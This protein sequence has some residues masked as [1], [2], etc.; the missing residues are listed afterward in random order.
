MNNTEPEFTP[1][2]A[3]PTS[4]LADIHDR[5]MEAYYGKMGEQFMRE[6]QSR[7]HWICA[8]VSGRKVL[9]VGCSQGIVPLLLAREGC[10]VTGVDISP[11]AI[12][13]AKG[14][15]QSEPEHVQQKVTYI[16]ADFLS[17]D[18]QDIVADT[19]VISEVLEHLVRPEL[20][21]EKAANLL[22]PGGCLIITV[23]F[24]V[25]DFID[26]KQTF[27]VLEPYRLLN[28][29]LQICEIK[30]IGKWLGM[31]ARKVEKS[32][33][34]S[35][36]VFDIEY[37][38]QLEEAFESIER[39]LRKSFVELSNRLAQANSKYRT[40]TEQI[41]QLKHQ[42][43]SLELAKNRLTQ[44]SSQQFAHLESRLA[45]AQVQL[46]ARDRE[47]QALLAQNSSAHTQLSKELAV[48][49]NKLHA[50]NLKY[51]A[52]TGEQIPA[53]KANLNSLQ[54][55][56][57]AQQHR[58][59]LLSTD[60]ARAI[61]QRALAEQRLIKTRASTTFQLGY[62]IKSSAHS[63]GGILRL[64][65]KL[66]R[67]YRKASEQR[68]RVTQKQ[69][70]GATPNVASILPP[71]A[72]IDRQLPVALETSV[73][74]RNTLLRSADEP[75]RSIKVA[76]IMDAFTFSSYRFECDLLQLTPQHWKQELDSFQPALLFI[77]SA[78]RG[79]DGLWGSKV[80]HN[81]QELQ[82]ILGWCKQH[83][84]PTV[85]WNKEDPVHFESFLNT[86]KQF[87]H[88][89]TTDIDCIH[90]YK[91][92][93]GH[94]RVYLLP[95]ACQPA[96]HNPVELYQRKEAFC[97]AGAYYARYPERTQ[98]LGNF[99]AHL[100]TL[101]P[102]DIFDRNFG[103]NDANYQF[104][105]AYQPFIVGTLAFEQIDMAYKGYRYALN[106]NSIKQSQ[107]MF[108]RRV[109]ELLGSNTLTVSNFSRGVRLLFGEL[110]LSTD[111]AEEVQRRL[112]RLAD[113][114]Q[115]ID[116][117]RLAALRKVMLEH[118]YEQRLGYVLSK[119]HGKPAV[120]QLPEI[121]VL[122]A[123]VDRQ[124]FEAL[125]AHLARQTHPNVRLFIVTDGFDSTGVQEDPRVR[126]FKRQSINKIKIAELLGNT[127]WLA[128]FAAQDY[129]GPNYL[130]DLA[131][132]TRYSQALLVG[133]AAYSTW[134]GKCVELQQAEQAYR[135]TRQFAARR[136]LIA[137]QLVGEQS[138][139]AWFKALPSLH[140][141]HEL[142][143]A[144]DA[145]N[146]CEN[147]S[148]CPSSEV[149]QHVDDL[150]L[151]DG[152]SIDQLQA[153]AEAIA[154][155]PVSHDARELSGRELSELFGALGSKCIDLEV[156]TDSWQVRSDLGDGKHE[157]LYAKQELGLEQL[158]SANG[159]LKLYLDCTP[160]LNLQLVVLFLDAQKQRISH[161]IQPA[162]RNHTADIPTEAAYVRLGL[163]VYANGCADIK[164]LVLGHRNLQ[165][166]E[167]L[168]KAEHLLLTNHYP[169]YDDL[170][171][172]GFVHSRVTAYQQQGVNVDVFRLRNHE[173][174]SY[175]EYQNV[176]VVTGCQ[177]T[178]A[179]MLDAGQYK[180]ILVHFLDA[181][182]W[183]VLRKYLAT[184]RI[185]VWVH[186]AE[187]QPWWRRKHNYRTE[188]QLALAKLQS[189]ARMSFWTEV[190][191][192]M[193]VNLSLVFV[194]KYLAEEVMEDI[195]FRLP[196][197]QY[198]IIHNPI[199]TDLFTYQEKPEAQRMKILSIRPFAS[200][201]Y[202]NDLSVKAIELLANKPF[203]KDLEIR[204]I[205]DGV[206]FE[207][208]LAPLRKYPN[209][210][211]ERRF[212][213]HQEIACLHKSHGIFLC[214]TRSDTHGVSRDEAMASGLIPVTNSV[215]AI[216]EFVDETCGLLAPAEDAFAMADGISLIVEKPELFKEM[217]IAARQ[218][219]E[220][221]TAK[222]L[223]IAKEL[224]AFHAD[225]AAL[226]VAPGHKTS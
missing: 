217:S 21:V 50:A 33:L 26:H 196:E 95:F 13:Q 115:S 186:G 64:P 208:T 124:Q 38:R 169:A 20:F 190:L 114:P 90:R 11:Q 204:L 191:Q 158:D 118:T 226:R 192:P 205:G 122:C 37:V 12:E 87:D 147:A 141:T 58:V 43:I 185:I 1:N 75:T 78:W 197:T 151:D 130:L 201:I 8:Q 88:V 23:P 175:H 70:A 103:N 188:E 116:K 178:L 25:N 109:F 44:E 62:Q 6:T 2:L 172:N 149:H 76:C 165:P 85:F 210:V 214:P 91:G 32:A 93:L 10:D 225:N 182:M 4:P 107:S 14:Y 184:T 207:E 105:P 153:R 145:F 9:D 39:H 84:V 127:A 108:A 29:H 59:E 120:Q 52:A 101:H 47:A 154:P 80:G 156:D 126:V 82:Q 132:A 19:I 193:P 179:K 55:K 206:M 187:V 146:Y 68:A 121:A 86:A 138:L 161:L 183:A 41:D 144:I 164:A 189:A 46:L 171:R 56:L 194:S 168:G 60:L 96:L 202:A 148:N 128:S 123:A 140:Y 143:L 163:R 17:L 49:R 53:L 16:N 72:D 24:G 209:V 180:T 133:K 79:K 113:A 106:L 219:I 137:R 150:Q 170:Y 166:S 94:E 135:P 83:Q 27:Y 30:V 112:Q 223:I 100:P 221:Q 66:L 142:G 54:K 136:A 48:S 3:E 173:T 203:F 134:N 167:L 7:I 89:F 31:V 15:M 57:S 74:A 51:R 222:N 139:N 129:Y 195:G 177:A 125:L 63:L 111:N 160:G 28:E 42:L 215:T 110:V 218:R 18:I 61:A 45:D 67:L 174:V 71:Q 176:D 162:N 81:S 119:V 65:F 211:I 157:Y 220:T 159:V 117:L 98:D 69:L 40:A 224:E 73:H 199:D 212:I 152:I 200:P 92:A 181:A 22:T 99:A 104:P 216:P 34:T 131:L 5:V 35:L 155:L 198:Q 97:F 77:E 36:N 213:N 102:L